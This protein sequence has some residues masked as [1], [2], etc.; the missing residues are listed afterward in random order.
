MRNEPQ[1][2]GVPVTLGFLRHPNLRAWE[3]RSGSFGFREL[4]PTL[5]L[6][7]ATLYPSQPGQT[8][9][10][11]QAIGGIPVPAIMRGERA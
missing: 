7:N 5:E 8:V 6:G 9:L 2:F 1:R 4:I 11:G 3:L 10:T